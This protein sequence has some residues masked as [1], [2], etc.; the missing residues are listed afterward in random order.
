MLLPIAPNYHT[1]YL[2]PGSIIPSGF[3]PR[4]PGRY[5][6]PAQRLGATGGNLWEAPHSGTVSAVHAREAFIGAQQSPLWRQLMYTFV[7]VF[8]CVY[9]WGFIS[10]APQ[11]STWCLKSRVEV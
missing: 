6:W 7:F 11:K 3:A 9:L 1:N 2:L 5:S 8:K 4:F 10:S